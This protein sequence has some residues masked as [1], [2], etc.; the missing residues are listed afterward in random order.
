MQIEYFIYKKSNSHQQIEYRT[1]RIW[2][3]LDWIHVY[4]I[5]IYIF[6]TEYMYCTWNPCHM[7]IYIFIY[8]HTT[9]NASNAG[10][11]V[12]IANKMHIYIY[13]YKCKILAS[14]TSNADFQIY[15]ICNILNLLWKGLSR[16]HVPSTSF[17]ALAEFYPTP[18]QIVSLYIVTRKKIRNND[19]L[20][21]LHHFLCFGSAALASCTLT[22]CFL[23][24]RSFG[25]CDR[26]F[27]ID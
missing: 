15:S 13:N 8:L 5:Y 19:L 14:R 4:C 6:Q 3:M 24:R 27:Y 11:R 20:Y 10:F 16:K 26:I 9:R 17:P 22:S 25:S 21:I 18:V 2:K 12:Y 7:H 1:D 23:A